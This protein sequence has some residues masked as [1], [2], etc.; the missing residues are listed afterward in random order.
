M[1]RYSVE[2]KASADKALQRLP[3]AIQRRIVAEVETLADNPRP[4]G[5]VKLAGDDNAWRIRVGDYRVVYE[6]HDKHLLVLVV[7]V[8]YRKDIYQKGK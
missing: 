7:R 1:H 4:A 3:V 5:C 8:G 6:V 2:F